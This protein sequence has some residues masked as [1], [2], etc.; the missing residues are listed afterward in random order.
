M[1]EVNSEVSL[2]L[3]EIFKL[4]TWGELD[5]L[6]D[7]DEADVAGISI[8]EKILSQ[9]EFGERFLSFPVEIRSVE[10][11][12]EYY[13]EEA[14]FLSLYQDLFDSFPIYSTAHDPEYSSESDNPYDTSMEPLRW[15]IFESTEEFLDICTDSLREKRFMHLFIPDLELMI[16]GSYDLEECV[17][18]QSDKGKHVFKGYV[19]KHGLFLLGLKS[20]S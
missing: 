1:K 16:L 7:K 19:E 15:K 2:R 9:E 13:R 12:Q 20:C 18:F 11:L 10:R 6:T 8:F 14:K 5:D 3:Q 4:K 17:V